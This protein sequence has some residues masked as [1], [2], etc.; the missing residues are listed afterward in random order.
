M[1]TDETEQKHIFLRK[2]LMAT[3]WNHKCWGLIDGYKMIS[4][5]NLP[6]H[7]NC[8]QKLPNLYTK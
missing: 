3:A 7:I 4:N 5:I 8:I 6:V 2:I 1:S